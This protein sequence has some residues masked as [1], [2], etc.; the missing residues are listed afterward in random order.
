[1]RVY[2]YIFS[3]VLI[4]QLLIIVDTRINTIFAEYPSAQTYLL[5]PEYSY[6]NAYVVI[7]V[8]AT[9]IG[10]YAAD[11]LTKYIERITGAE[12]TVIKEK[13]DIEYFGFY[14]GK[15]IKGG[16]Y[17]PSVISPHD[18]A[19]G[20]RIKSIPNGL[21]IVGGD[22][23]STLFGVYAF[24]EEYQGCGWFLPDELGE[25]VPRNNGILIP[26]NID[27]TQI[28]D[29]PI[30]WIGRGDWALKNRMNVEVLINGHDVGVINKWN[31]HTFLT[32]VPTRQYFDDHPE[33]YPLIGNSRGR[34]Q[35]CTSNPEVIRLVTQHIID[36]IKRNPSINF[37]GLTPNDN[38][39]YCQC[40][41]CKAQVIPGWEDDRHGL[42]TGPIHTF[43][44]EVARR[45]KKF[46]P[47]QYIKIGAYHGYLR[48]PP[49]PLYKPEDNLALIFTPH[50]HYCHNHPI[51]D[52]TCPYI[53]F[54]MSEYYKWASNTKH[55]QIFAYECLHGWANLIWPMVHVL[56][57]D[58]PEYHRTG[59]E[60]FFTQSM[61]LT[62]SYALNYYVASKLAWDSSLDVNNLIK[63]FCEKSYGA[64]GA[65][66]EKYHKFIEDSWENNP[67]HVAYW[68]EEIPVSLVQFF[69][70]EVVVNADRLLREA[71]AVDADSLSKQ[72]VHLIRIDF[73]Y[74]RLVL[75][76]INAVSKPFDGIDKNDKTAVGNA[77]KQA[78]SIGDV[79]AS[80][81]RKYFEENLPESLQSGW[82]K[83]GLESLLRTHNRPAS[84]PGGPK[85]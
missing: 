85:D 59:V 24:L 13:P 20:F 51:T 28:P 78:A 62:Q 55:M 39:N 66:M 35:I 14:I 43:N 48:Y 5:L 4:V 69:P 18:G 58:M 11:E 56:K 49:D 64:A 72:R 6:F 27:V 2:K 38:Y 76:Y 7:P 65:A 75:N 70:Q 36:E 41:Y 80:T 16:N 52:Q 74:L 73:D 31:F 68:T 44:N 34:S 54:F 57:K 19:N 23:L 77:I 46:C 22:D 10:R 17:A 61:S 84:I 60:Q 37:I 47:E 33:Y 50:I 81:I 53:K 29:I 8:R 12:I 63:E 42:A 3:I 40:S 32:L 26:E 9:E 1:M 67:N 82:P 71:E 21:V 30:R 25:V 79:L 15:T 45:V 83:T